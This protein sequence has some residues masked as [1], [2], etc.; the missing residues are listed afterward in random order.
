MIAGGFQS[1]W[2]TSGSGIKKGDSNHNYGILGSYR[3]LAQVPHQ[4][5]Q[6]LSIVLLIGHEGRLIT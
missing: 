1:Y 2:V 4:T 6:L 3:V 5:S